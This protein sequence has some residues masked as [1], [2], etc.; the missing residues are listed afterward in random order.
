MP[1]S[2]PSGKAERA[3]E[4]LKRRSFG[5]LATQSTHLPGYPFGSV[6]PYV[7]DGDGFP[8]ILISTLALHTKNIQKDPK[9]SLTVWEDEEGPD[10]QAAGRVT[11]VGDAAP[12][13][14]GALE[15]GKARYLRYQ[16]SA[17]G[18]FAMHDFVLHRIDL[19][20]VRYIGGFGAIYWVEPEDM[21]VENP[22]LEHEQGI[23]EHV[24]QDH[25]AGLVECLELQ[26]GKKTARVVMIGVDPAGFDV[27]A[28]DRRMR[29]RFEK[30]ARVPD[31]VRREMIR[32]FHTKVPQ[33]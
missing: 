28:D 8:L 2:S 18:H 23:L 3:R 17:E 25:A 29:I 33:L 16:P 30:Q 32:V 24:N 19:K 20:R 21:Q 11:W 14:A 22:L 15:A 31:E 6:V 5:V 7:L 12:V 4:L 10:Q 27:L 1:E 26:T 9:V 13:A